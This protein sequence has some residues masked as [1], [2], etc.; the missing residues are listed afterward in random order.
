MNR[1][2][3]ILIGIIFIAFFL[4]FFLLSSVPPSASLDEASIGY[5]AYS[6]LKTGTDEYGN[7]FP[8]LLRAYD[9][10]RPALYIYLV[11]PFVKILGL[12]ALSVRLPS[13]ILSVITVIATYFLVK[14]IFLNFKNKIFLAFVSSFLLAI[15]PWHIYIS[16]EFALAKAS[17]TVSR[18]PI[19]KDP[20]ISAALTELE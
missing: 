16:H 2:L 17:S 14:E 6:I 9:D 18:L 5:N 7:K 1:N 8:I 3:L 4:R 10:W 11:I 12:N 15:S 13:V 19:L 20:A